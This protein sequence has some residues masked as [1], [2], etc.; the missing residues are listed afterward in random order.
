MKCLSACQNAVL[1][2]LQSYDGRV[3]PVFMLAE[4]VV[5]DKIKAAEAQSACG[6]L[7]S[8]GLAVKAGEG[9]YK[10]SAAAKAAMK[11]QG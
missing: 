2:Q 8:L 11:G 3:V 5:S 4:A 9:A 10:L 6:E 7:C 1:E